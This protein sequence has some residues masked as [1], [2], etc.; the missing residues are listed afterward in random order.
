[1]PS[2][3][4][5]KVT[6]V[7]W[8]PDACVSVTLGAEKGFEFPFEDGNGDAGV[9]GIK[10]QHHLFVILFYSHVPYFLQGEC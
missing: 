10:P 4:A 5:V 9:D 7:S 6:S 3:T 2:A 8:L 1:M